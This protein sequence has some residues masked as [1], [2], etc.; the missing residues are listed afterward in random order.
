MKDNITLLPLTPQAA[1]FSFL[2]TDC[3]SYL[4][5]SQLLLISKLYIYKSRK[6]KFLS[7]TC[8]LKEISKIKN[9]EKNSICKRKKTNMTYKRKWELLYK[10]FILR[11]RDAYLL[12]YVI[13]YAFRLN[14]I[15][16][17][18]LFVLCLWFDTDFVSCNI[19]LSNLLIPYFLIPT[20]LR[21]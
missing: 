8:L 18:T 20:W 7:R 3:Q 19:P 14:V 16:R 4:I 15:L 21:C 12:S 9:K 17:V 5:Q 13:F 6:S 10:T 2:E 1:I 11:V